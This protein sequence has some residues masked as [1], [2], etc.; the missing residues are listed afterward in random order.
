MGLFQK[1]ERS[2]QIKTRQ[3]NLAKASSFSGL[4][5]AG[6]SNDV[7]NTPSSTSDV[8][9]VFGSTAGRAGSASVSGRGHR[10]LGSLLAK[11]RSSAAFANAQSSDKSSEVK[12]KFKNFK[13]AISPGEFRERFK[14]GYYDAASLQLKGRTPPVQAPVPTPDSSSDKK[15]KKK[16][17]KAPGHV[18]K[19]LAAR[20]AKNNG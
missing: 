20:Q 3:A 13:S 4:P 1:L 16:K 10:S 6:G 11:A 8:R 15:K 7:I 9:R 19:A 17:E 12:Q 18:N 14:T 5:A 2:K